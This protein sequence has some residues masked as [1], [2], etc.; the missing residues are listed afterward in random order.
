MVERAK[1]APVREM[2]GVDIL[3]DAIDAARINTRL[4]DVSVNF[5]HR[6]FFTFIREEPF[7]EIV[8]D[9]P[10][11]VA[12]DV[13]KEREIEELYRRFFERA[14]ELL[15]A[16]GR[17]LILTHDRALVRR[18]AQQSFTCIREFELSMKEGSY[19]FLLRKGTGR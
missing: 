4:A 3:G 6:D 18:Y 17:M 7:A 10:F 9:M 15:S 16:D 8:T 12:G 11:C 2:V 1:R 13:E 19:L 5:I 14:P